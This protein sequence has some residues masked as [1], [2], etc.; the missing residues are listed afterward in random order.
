MWDEKIFAIISEGVTDQVVLE[1][2]LWGWTGDKNLAIT[3][4][5]PPKNEAGGWDKVFKYCKS[6][7]FKGAFS[8][9]DIVIIQIDTDFMQRGEVSAEFSINI[10]NLGVEDI[11]TAF[12][13][14]FIELIGNEFYTEHEKQILFAIS[15][16][17]IECWLLP[18]YFPDKH[19]IAAKTISCIS[20]LN[21]V[22]KEKKGIYI[23]KKSTDY[24][25]TI[26]KGHFKKRVDIE[27]CASKNPS[28]GI[29]I[30]EVSDKIGEIAP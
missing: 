29:F 16:N 3:M 8:F 1:H 13:N 25:E 2:I 5:Q 28:F 15:V 22:L 14:K 9:C 30:Q 20:T 27:K 24:Y 12:K 6:D 10:Q 26:L 17:E 11:V 19:T 23:D 4:L 7:D 21:P 18:I